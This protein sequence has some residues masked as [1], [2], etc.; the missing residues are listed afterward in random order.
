MENQNNT[1]NDFNELDDLRRQIVDLKNK[2]DQQGRLNENLVKNTIKRKMKGVHRTIWFMAALVVLAIPLYLSMMADNLLSM[3]FT[4]FTI[5]MLMVFVL[6]DYFINRMDIGHMNDDLMETARKL[7]QMKK[8]RSLSQK[9]G[10]AACVPWLAWFCYEIISHDPTGTFTGSRLMI[11]IISV[12]IGALT[13]AAIGICIFR[14]MQRANDEMINQI[15]E[16]MSEQ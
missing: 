2:V 9:I 8:N 3:P 16:L 13:G 11:F 4:I 10:I 6:A 7:T 14:K 5:V 1:F 12:I 15:N